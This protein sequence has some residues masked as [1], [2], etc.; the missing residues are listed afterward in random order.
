MYIEFALENPE[1]YEVMFNMP[2]PRNF[3]DLQAREGGE[4]QDWAMQ[5]YRFLREG[6]K[7]LQG[8]GHF[9]G[10]DTD[11][12]TLALWSLIHGLVSLIIRKRIPYP[13]AASKELAYKVM[14]LFVFNI[15]DRL[16]QPADG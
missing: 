8:V 1:Y 5:S 6:V 11:I 12:A 14:D 13:Q 4:G 3:M 7:E 9:Q 2:E 16:Q 15:A 10:I